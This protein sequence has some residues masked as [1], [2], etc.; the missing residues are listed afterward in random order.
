MEHLIRVLSALLSD[1]NEL[2]MKLQECYK[3]IRQFL[4][5]CFC[6]PF[7][8]GVEGGGLSEFDLLIILHSSRSVVFHALAMFPEVG[9]SFLIVS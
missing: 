9:E 5:L 7:F 3:H 6:S 1:L 2:A 8:W 4:P